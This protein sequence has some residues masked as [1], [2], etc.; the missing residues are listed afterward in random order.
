MASRSK[1]R[2]VFQ[3]ATASSSASTLSKRLF[4]ST[5]TWSA[6]RENRCPAWTAWAVAN[7]TC[8]HSGYSRFDIMPPKVLPL[9][10]RIDDPGRADS[11]DILTKGPIRQHRPAQ[12]LPIGTLAPRDDI[13]NRRQGEFL[14]I[15]MPMDHDANLN[16]V[17]HRRNQTSSQPPRH[18]RRLYENIR[19]FISL[20]ASSCPSRFPP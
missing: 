17:R 10:I 9:R 16:A 11:L 6:S 8:S 15:Q 12:F 1:A 20:P 2:A 13:I 14:M 7:S 3:P 5:N 18:V 19:R 4:K